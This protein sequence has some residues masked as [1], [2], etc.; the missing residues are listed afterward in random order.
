L[1]VIRYHEGQ[2]FTRHETWYVDR[3]RVEVPRYRE[4]E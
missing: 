3:P 2:L 4:G 1:S